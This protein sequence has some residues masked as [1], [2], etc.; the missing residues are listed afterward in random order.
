VGDALYELGVFIGS[1]PAIGSVAT[2]SAG[3]VVFG[4]AEKPNLLHSLAEAIEA[5][6]PSSGI[7]NCS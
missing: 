1:E 6:P 3:S 5:N 7:C 4:T 2:F